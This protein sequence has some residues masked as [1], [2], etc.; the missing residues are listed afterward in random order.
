MDIFK[1]KSV[2]SKEIIPKE[3]GFNSR[4]FVTSSH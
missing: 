4:V 3:M 2:I 1:S